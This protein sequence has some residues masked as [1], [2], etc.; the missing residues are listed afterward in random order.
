[1]RNVLLIIGGAAALYFLGRYKFSQKISFLLRGVRAGGGLTNPQIL[2]D[3]AI[4]N[5]TNQ[6][7][8]LK[9]ITGDISINGQYIANL[10][11]FGDQVIQPNS[12]SL[13]KLNARPSATGVGQFLV[14]LFRERQQG[15][16]ATFVG[17]ANVDGVTYPVNETR[18]I[19]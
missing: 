1:M 7:A 6:K 13:I 16:S 12:E 11:A 18:K 19:R 8:T 2:I 10:S 4:Q 14:T 15:I 9:S 5:P 3:L 17:T